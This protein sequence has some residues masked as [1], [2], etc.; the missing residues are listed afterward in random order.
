MLLKLGIIVR[1]ANEFTYIWSFSENFKN[2][3][4]L[5]SCRKDCILLVDMSNKNNNII[6]A[7]FLV[8]GGLDIMV[9]K[10]KTLTY[11]R[12]FSENLEDYKIMIL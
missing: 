2:Y 10:A 3:K 1:K 5:I 12:S 11:F 7:L 6:F 9:R 8:Q 4:T